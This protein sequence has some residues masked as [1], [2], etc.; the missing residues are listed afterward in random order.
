MWQNNQLASKD[1]LELLLS[2]TFYVLGAV[3]DGSDDSSDDDVCLFV[4][5]GVAGTPTNTVL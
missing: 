3:D 2:N 5:R 4:G 1:E